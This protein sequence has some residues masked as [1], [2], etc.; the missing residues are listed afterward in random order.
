MPI[1]LSRILIA[2]LLVASVATVAVYS[3]EGEDGFLHS[4]QAK[5]RVIVSPVGEL[6]A[7]IG[8]AVEGGEEAAADATA[9]DSTLSELKAR[10]AELTEAL[11]KA[12][13]YRLEAQR[14]EELLNLKDQYGIEG[15]SGRVVGRSTDAWS[16]T[17]TLDVGSNDGVSAGLT[18]VG[19]FGV[20]GQVISVD[21]GSCTVRLVTDP[22]SGVAAMVQSSRVEGIVRGSLSGLLYLEGVEM[23]V[24]VSV[25]DV[26]MTSGLGGSFT[27]GLLIGTIVRVEGDATDDSRRIVVSQAGSVSSLEEAMVVFSAKDSSGSSSS[28]ESAQSEGDSE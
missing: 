6:G 8:A 2:V 5:V 9:S 1:R 16:Q 7:G 3:A 21:A 22:S 4:V 11:V 27:K 17:I 15:V 18:V 24:D 14:L 19:G 28:P 20:V 10:N 13:E 12:E 26:V 23:G 25:G